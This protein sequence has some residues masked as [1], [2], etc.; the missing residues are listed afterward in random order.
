[1]TAITYGATGAAI[2]TSAAAVAA[3]AN[4][5]GFWARVYDAFVQAQMRRAIREIKLHQHLLPA[6]L[7]IAGNKITYRSEDQLPFVR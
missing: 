1:M 2:S 3:P 5:K 7:E 6:D 4:R